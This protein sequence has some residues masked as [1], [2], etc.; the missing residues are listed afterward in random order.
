MADSTKYTSKLSKSSIL[1]FGGSSGIG[2]GVAEA[3]LENGA[4]V[5][6]SSSSQSRV[7]EAVKELQKSYPSKKDSVSG[8]VCD[9]GSE[10]M[11]SNIVKALDAVTTKGKLDHI[12]HTAG[13]RLA[14][15]PLAELSLEK[16]RKA[17]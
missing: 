7:D 11:E 15:L 10:D 6:I 12:V 1:I 9:L 4:T 2:Y 14:T 17:G 13:D 8:V 16:I 5:Y 3:V